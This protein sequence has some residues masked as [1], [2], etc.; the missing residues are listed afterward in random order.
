MTNIFKAIKFYTLATKLEDGQSIDLNWL[1]ILPIN[2]TRNGSEVTYTITPEKT[3]SVHL[4]RDGED[5]VTAND[6]GETINLV[7]VADTAEFLCKCI[8][9]GIRAAFA[10]A[11][12]RHIDIHN[13]GKTVRIYDTEICE[14]IAIANYRAGGYDI[15]PAD[16]ECI[17]SPD[18]IGRVELN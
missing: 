7:S 15:W 4:D 16:V 17:D 5:I 11:G 18:S 6:N 12:Y 1:G 10:K 13:D 8:A 3:I 14:Y 9:N 2:G